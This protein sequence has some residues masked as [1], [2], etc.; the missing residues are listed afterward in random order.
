MLV[1]FWYYFSRVQM[2]FCSVSQSTDV[3]LWVSPCCSGIKRRHDSWCPT[4]SASIIGAEAVPLL[5][6]DVWDA[7]HYHLPASV[8][9]LLSQA[10]GTA[11]SSSSVSKNL[12]TYIS[13]T[14]L[15]LLVQI[16]GAKSFLETTKLS[17]GS[18]PFDWGK[19]IFNFLSHFPSSSR[20]G[21][22]LKRI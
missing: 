18:D 6:K 10:M 11:C 1:S 15:G 13:F 17:S 12:W 4:C 9:S 20:L 16:L 19:S 8:Q 3:S 2:A 5:S 14:H 22:W 21:C 7:P